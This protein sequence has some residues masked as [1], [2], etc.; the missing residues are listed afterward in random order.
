MP[1][2]LPSLSL[3]CQTTPAY[4]L[5]FVKLH[6]RNNHNLDRCETPHQPAGRQ[7][8]PPRVLA[9]RPWATRLLTSFRV[10]GRCA[11]PPATF[12]ALGGPV[13][14]HV[15]CA[16]IPRNLGTIRY[17]CNLPHQ[18]TT[19]I[20]DKT[21]ATRLRRQ[22]H[23]TRLMWMHVQSLRRPSTPHRK[24]ERR[25]SQHRAPTENHAH[26]ILQTPA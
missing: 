7:P 23:A 25:V 15:P 5:K 12:R 16:N 2:S 24:A 17:Q 9:G 18:W 6:F 1:H 20:C 10:R 21:H 8:G 3:Q 19:K 22:T 11:C 14:P 4:Y 13:V 26:P